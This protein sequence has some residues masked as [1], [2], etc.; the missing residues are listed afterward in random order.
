MTKQRARI[1]FKYT[2]PAMPA[3]A[4]LKVDGKIVGH[5]VDAIPKGTF[6]GTHVLA[7][8]DVDMHYVDKMGDNSGYGVPKVSFLITRD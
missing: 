3:G 5:L 4:P 6:M 2:G 8:A 7:E 1:S